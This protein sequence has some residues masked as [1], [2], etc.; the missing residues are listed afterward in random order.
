MRRCLL[1]A[2]ALLA[3]LPAA[4]QEYPNRVIRFIVSAA[5]GGSNDTVA[6]VLSEA[7]TGQLP[8]PVI[9]ENRP[10]AQG[11]LGA[12]AVV[13]APPDGHTALLSNTGQ[14]GLR[15]MAP[16]APIDV[17]TALTPV[18]VLA[19][20]PMVMLVAN[21]VPAR[22]LREFLAM[23]RA[24]P[25]RFDYATSSGAGTLTL[26]ALLFI[27][28]TGLEMNAVP[29]RGGAPAQM[30]VIAGR[31]GVVFDVATVALHTARAGQ[32]R[33]F[34][35]SSAQRSPFAPEVPTWR[36]MGV[37]AE[38]TVWQALWVSAATPRPIQQALHDAVARVLRTERFRAR[39]AELGADRVLDLDLDQ[40]KAYVAAEVVRWESLLGAPPRR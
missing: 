3:A 20:S 9:V 21:N 34:A 32:A 18:A 16:N 36:E 27:K 5:P 14:A 17:A 2:L 4:A 39:M 38:M 26:A 19:E 30:D 12:Q 1:A 23:A 35:V 7:L 28:T 33:A 6:R 10:G 13:S 8:H 37:D 25:G 24:E 40:A 31:I 15:A 22:D 11:M 29:Y